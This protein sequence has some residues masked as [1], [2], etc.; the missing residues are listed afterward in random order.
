MQM[1]APCSALLP[2]ASSTASPA[3]VPPPL[4]APLHPASRSARLTLPA[5]RVSAH[6]GNSP[7]AARATLA[8][9]ASPPGST[10]CPSSAFPYSEKGVA[11]RF[12]PGYVSPP[13]CADAAPA[14]VDRAALGPVSTTVETVLPAPVSECAPRPA[15]PSSACARNWPGSAPHLRSRFRAPGPAPTRRTTG[16]FLS[17]PCQSVPVAP[18]ADKTRAPLPRHAAPWFRRSPHSRCPTTPLVASWDGN[19]TL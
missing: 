17:P 11:V 3:D 6:A 9:S 16:C 12:S 14:A 5:D 2:V 15:C 18:V 10:A 19:H 13:A 4:A 8:A 1:P 7:T